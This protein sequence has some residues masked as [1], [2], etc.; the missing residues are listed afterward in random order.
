MV[1]GVV[2]TNAI[3]NWNANSETRL[4]AACPGLDPDDGGH[5]SQQCVVAMSVSLVAVLQTSI[6]VC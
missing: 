1:N 6:V 4:A 5:Q 2:V 3:Q